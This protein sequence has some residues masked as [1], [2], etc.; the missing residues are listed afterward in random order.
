MI[1][2]NEAETSGE[3]GCVV[4]LM[5]PA[6]YRAGAFAEAAR[7]IGL[8]LVRAIDLPDELATRRHDA[9]ALDFADPNG[10]VERIL[11]FAR[12]RTPGV[13]AILALDDRGALIAAGASAALGLAHNDPGSALAARDKFA[14]RERLAAGGVPVPPYTR[15]PAGIDP[16]TIADDIAYPSVVKPLLLSGSRG[17]IRADDPDQFVAAFGRTRAILEASGMA[18][19]EHAILVER[20]VP[21][22]E[23][24]LEGLLTGGD[25]QTLAL[26]DKP[27]PLDG[28]FFEETIYVTPSRLPA[29]VQAAISRRTAEAARAIGLRGGPVH[30]ELRI[31]RARDEIWLIELAGRSI[32]GLCSSILEFGAGM[33]LEELILRHAAGLPLGSTDRSDGA[34]GVM[35]IPIPRRG[36]LRGID[37]LEPASAVPGV[38][39][40]EITAPLN[41]PIVPLPEGESYLG[42]IFA[43][44]ETPAEAEAALREAHARLTLR[45]DPLIPLQRL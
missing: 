44:R 21:G 1:Q 9:L 31:D 43:R 19:D 24:A 7:R 10:S 15:F 36:I 22:V 8:D 37:G 34:A 32:G 45:I 6:T 18:P 14:M 40:I 39:G 11:A 29:E 12:D 30:A 4:A 25:L 16:A 27:D 26:F 42:F 28:P 23:V 5:S 20:F 3:P 33:G 41:Q 35:M 2:R 17:V 13:A 38:T